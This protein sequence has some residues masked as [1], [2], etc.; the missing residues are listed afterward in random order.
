MI[1]GIGTDLTDA[2]R[3]EKLWQRHGQRFAS[4]ILHPKEQPAFQSS[5][6]PVRYL[7]KAWA[8]KEAAAKAVGTGFV[9]L[10]PHEIACLRDPQGKPVLSVE[11]KAGRF[12]VSISDEGQQVLAFVVWESNQ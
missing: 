4:R 8:V 3:I 10:A 1:L 2:G 5:A 6:Q 9:G 11:G 7:A 12:H